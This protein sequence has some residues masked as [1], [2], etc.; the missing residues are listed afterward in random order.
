[1]T[2][3]SEKKRQANGRK[4][5]KDP[6]KYALW[7]KSAGRCEYSGCNKR[8]YI[9]GFLTWKPTKIAE[10]AHI[11][12]V[13]E[14]G[15]R[16]NELSDY[17]KEYVNSIDNLMLLCRDCHKRIDFHFKDEHSTELLREMKR[18]H[19]ERIESLTDIKDTKKTKILK[20]QAK[21]HLEPRHSCVNKMKKSLF[22][23]F[24]AEEQAIVI[25]TKNSHQ[26]DAQLNYWE[27]EQEHLLKE[28]DRK[29]TQEIED[30]N[31]SHLSIF[32]FAPMPL[33]ILLGSLLTDK[34]DCEIRQLRREPI[35]WE[36]SYEEVPLDLIIEKPSEIKEIPAILFALSSNLEIEEVT[37]L[38]T[39]A[40]VWKVT[41]PDPNTDL[42]QSKNQLSEFRKKI[43]T[44]LE[45]IK[46]TFPNA[47]ELHI[48]PAMPVSTC[49]EFGRVL[50]PK[51]VPILQ[52]YDKREQHFQ[53]VLTINPR[54]YNH[55]HPTH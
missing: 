17:E 47:T 27:N 10:L 45:E 48:F 7:A 3:Y 34:R 13:Q 36:W 2:I 14:D 39:N 25:E 16:G 8:L 28:F 23:D 21:I 51:I 24:Y 52:I 42:I 49:I 46:N 30:G 53:N 41:V 22:P 1:M 20:Y 26:N 38:L 4:E 37:R 35:T 40:S 15:P 32:A 11:L 12:A 18:K 43:R 5:I 50:L 31:I 33:L 29:I 9:D 19:E 44:L 6:V 55:A 54:G